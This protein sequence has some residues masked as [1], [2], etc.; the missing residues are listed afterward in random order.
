MVERRIIPCAAVAQK[1]LAL[2]RLGEFLMKKVLALVVAFALCFTALAGCFVTSAADPVINISVDNFATD[3]VVDITGD[4]GD[5]VNYAA[6]FTVTIDKAFTFAGLGDL[7][8]YNADDEADADDL[9]EPYWFDYVKTTD[10]EGNTVIKELN[11]H[12]NGVFAYTL[13][14]TAP[15]NDT[16]KAAVYEGAV[17]VELEYADFDATETAIADATADITVAATGDHKYDDGVVTADPTCTEAGVK[18]YTCTVCNDTYTEDIEATG[19]S[20]DEGVIDPDATCTEDGVKTYTCTCGDSYTEAVSAKGHTAGEAKEENRVEATEQAP[21]SYDMVVRCTVCNAIISSETHEIPQLAPSGPV[22]DSN[23]SITPSINLTET[24][25][26]RYIFAN[27]PECDDFYVQFTH[28]RCDGSY[29]FIDGGYVWT[30]YKSD[31]TVAGARYAYLYNQMRLYE[32]GI[33]VTAKIYCLDA[34]DNVIYVSEGNTTTVADQAKAGFASSSS[35]T[36]K[37]LYSDIIELGAVAQTYFVN[38]KDVD[39]ADVTLPNAG[40]VGTPSGD[41]DVSTLNSVNEYTTVDAAISM[42]GG[43]TVTG[44][45]VIRF[46]VNGASKFDDENLK[47]VVSYTSPKYGPKTATYKVADMTPSGSGASIRYFALFNSVA[48]C[49]GNQGVTAALYDGDTLVGSLDYS[50]EAAIAASST[51]SRAYNLYMHTAKLGASARA[52]WNL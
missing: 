19:H 27:I 38:G 34:N 48:L 23:I 12:D 7:I 32:L 49:D 44:N 21:G 17:V 29:N 25:N 41:I 4:L 33:E 8:E 36:A 45:P 6:V 30:V 11:A 50:I 52:H 43:L 16:C 31:L 9:G 15:A 2:C 18:T 42:A 20:Y 14:L 46:Q 35:A 13:E 51:S 5:A 40:F 3:G 22:V 26:L 28:D 47:L 10:G 39:L 24:I 1:I 37:T